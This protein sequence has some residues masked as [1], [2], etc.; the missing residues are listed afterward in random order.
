VDVPFFNYRATF[1]GIEEQLV[2]A[3]R[4]VVSRGAYIQQQ[5]LADFEAHIAEY[6]GVKHCIGVGNATDG[7]MMLWRAVGL[8]PGDEVIVPSHTMVATAASVV[9][10][11]GR[12]V[13]VDCGDDHLIDPASAEAAITERTKGIMP[14]QLNGRTADMDAIADLC[15]RYGLMLIEDAAQ[16]LG[17]T[18]KGRYAGTFGSGAAFSFYPAKLLGCLGDGGAVVT[19]DDE[20]AAK[21]HLLRDHGRAP[22]GDVVVWGYNSRLDN[23]QAAFLDLQLTHYSDAVA[24][25][26]QIAQRYQ[27]G[28]GDLPEVLLPPAPGDGDHFD[29]FQNYE[30]EGERRDALQEHLLSRGV[31][32]I[33][34][35]GGK[36]IHQFSELGLDRDLPRTELLFQRCLMLPLNTSLTD[37]E[38]DHVI[39]TVRE[40][41]GVEP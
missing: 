10:A 19:D 16:A 41:Y 14:V 20:I 28:L 5:D 30:I 2:D 13:L 24:R 7:L 32:T 4:D 38:V 34:Q 3:L 8:D 1:Q 37:A 31:R 25:R 27:D 26:R 17:S 29:V 22:S 36:A 33:R 15:E 9:H 23:L 35:W 12:P 18:F 39:A 11:G 6:L 21:V 40:F